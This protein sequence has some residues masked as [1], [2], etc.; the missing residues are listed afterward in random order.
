MDTTHPLIVPRVTLPELV[1]HDG[2]RP[3]VHFITPPPS[4]RRPEHADYM[5]TSLA[6]LTLAALARRAGWDAEVFDLHHQDPPTTRPDA[7]GITVWTVSAAMAYD[8][9]A[10]Y[11]AQGVP[12]VLG[13]AHVSVMVSEGC[14]HADAVVAGEAEGLLDTVLADALSGSLQPIYRGEWGSMDQVPGP[15]EYRRDLQRL[16]RRGVWAPP[17]YQSS[18]GC[19]FN[20]SFCSVIRINGRGQRHREPDEVVDHLRQM[21]NNGRRPQHVFFVDDDFAADPD[22]SIELSETMAAAD[23][24]VTFNIQTSIGIAEN[25]PLLDAASRAGL[26]SITMGLESLERSNVLAVNKKNRPGRYIEAI[27]RIKEYG[28]SPAASFIM[29]LPD[30]DPASLATLGARV[31]DLGLEHAVF[32]NLVPTP[33]TAVFAEHHAD[34]RIESYDWALYDGSN[35]VTRPPFGTARQLDELRM[36]VWRDYLAAAPDAF[37]AEVRAAVDRPLD[38]VLVDTTTDDPPWLSYVADP[39]D[40]ALASTVSAADANDAI[41]TSVD[42]GRKTLTPG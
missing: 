39:A 26:T 13:G 31:A 16:R 34:V 10:Q 36:Q 9:A 17:V 42:L 22:R 33:G 3:L 8:L 23:L 41:T 5:T 24:P 2:D 30:D 32:N 12:V 1:D 38:Q 4:I 14:R 27:A 37:S 25:R 35:S 15:H 18:R 29:G 40:I 21:T 19:R 28:I 11:R 20:C 7:V 6:S